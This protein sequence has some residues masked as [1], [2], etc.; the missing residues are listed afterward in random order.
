VAF[1]LL[2]LFLTLLNFDLRDIWYYGLI[3]PTAYLL[4]TLLPLRS[5]HKQQALPGGA[6]ALAVLLTAMERL[7]PLRSVELWAVALGATSTGNSGLLNFLSRYPF[8]KEQTLFVTL[9]N[10][11]GD[12]RVRAA[13]EGVL[14]QHAADRELI[15]LVAALEADDARISSI[16]RPYHSASSIAS[17]LHNRGYRALTL[18]ARRTSP[19]PA[20]RED[21]L[22]DFNDDLLEQAIRLIISLVKRLDQ[23]ERSSPLPDERRTLE[24]RKTERR[25][26]MQPRESEQERRKAVR[27][28]GERRADSQEQ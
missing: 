14:R 1:A 27:R 9:Q 13:H 23:D 21:V 20:A 8:P 3:P 10:I 7:G 28:R 4:L 19:R 25:K 18:F 6:G 17:S 22:H 11:D 24:R 15:G 12:Q 2:V 5:R 16:A 26:A